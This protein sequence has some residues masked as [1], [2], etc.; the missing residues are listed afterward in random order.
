M[1]IVFNY[2]CFVQLNC[3]FSTFTAPQYLEG[4]LG[5]GE[6][7][8]VTFT[9]GASRLNVNGKVVLISL[10]YNSLLTVRKRESSLRKVVARVAL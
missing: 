1:Q 3:D 4:L 9:V 2:I 7:E 8:C 5:S 6:T 10:A